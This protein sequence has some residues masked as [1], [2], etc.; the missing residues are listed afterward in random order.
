VRESQQLE[1]ERICQLP[2]SH[3]ATDGLASFLTRPGSSRA[4]R[5]V[6]LSAIAEFVACR[7]GVGPIGVGHGKT[8]IA[9][10]TGTALGAEHTIILTRP[11][12][13]KQLESDAIEARRDFHV[14]S[15][16]IMSY[17]AISRQKLGEP[18]ALE[19]AARGW[20]DDRLLIVADE[21]HA[22]KDIGSNRTRR[23][24]RFLTEHPRVMFV[25][26]S[27]TFFDRQMGQFSH[28]FDLALGRGSPY[29]RP[30]FQ[31]EHARTAQCLDSDGQPSHHD[32][33]AVS[34]M[35]RLYYPQVDMLYEGVS[36]RRKA[37]REAWAHRLAWTAG[38]HVAAG[39]S[40]NASIEI[41]C[42]P[43]KPTETIESALTYVRNTGDNLDGIPLLD[44]AQRASC[45]VTITFGYFFRTVWPKSTTEKEKKAWLGARGCY[46]KM[47]RDEIEFHS[48]HDYDSRGLIEQTMRQALDM[49]GPESVLEKAYVA[50]KEQEALIVPG[51]ECVWLDSYMVDYVVDFVSKQKQPWLIWYQGIPFGD[52]L[53]AKGLRVYGG[54]SNP[55]QD[56]AHTSICLSMD[57]HTESIN[58]QR[59]SRNLVLIPP[60]R[61]SK[62]E[63]LLGRTHRQ[64]QNADV[65]EVRVMS[66]TIELD[67]LLDKARRDALYRQTSAGVPE[68]LCFASWR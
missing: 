40:C 34:A 61:G 15:V 39:T 49:R 14:R 32:W 64:G 21:A 56:P 9:L 41:A 3:A 38:V 6:Q 18:A 66:G 11:G 65:I 35:W 29:P 24:T 52:A 42:V 26:L 7:G 1:I 27:G 20:P 37:L 19:V 45:L 55:E 16:E 4:L 31:I 44:D 53:A 33:A 12:A 51:S 50:W 25:A 28:L 30:R 60:G 22:L 63:Q 67:K 48:R 10:L 59:F 43:I 68:R 8:L 23:L 57:A 36:P 17:D 54:N 2:F 46:S 58:M 5:P 47:L 62:W 13:I